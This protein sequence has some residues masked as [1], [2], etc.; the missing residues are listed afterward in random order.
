MPCRAAA[1]REPT[2]EKGKKGVLDVALEN[3]FRRLKRVRLLDLPE[4]ESGVHPV[5]SRLLNSTIIATVLMYLYLLLFVKRV[6][7]LHIK[8]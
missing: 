2:K 1:A 6:V 8:H 7:Y 5:E 4:G 3:S